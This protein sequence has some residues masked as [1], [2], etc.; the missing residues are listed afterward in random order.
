MM[1][2]PDP[3]EVIPTTTP[4][5]APITSGGRGITQY[6]RG[7]HRRPPTATASHACHPHGEADDEPRQRHVEVDGHGPGPPRGSSRGPSLGHRS[8]FSIETVDIVD[9]RLTGSQILRI[10]RSVGE[11][12]LR[13]LDQ[14]FDRPGEVTGG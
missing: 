9:I 6:G 2:E 5:T 1:S 7:S 8:T 14:G 3:T 10:P 12:G 11:P 13:V 4:P